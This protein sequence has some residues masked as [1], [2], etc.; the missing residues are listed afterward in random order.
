MTTPIFALVIGV[1]NYLSDHFIT[2]PAAQSDAF[3]LVRLLIQQGVPES[4]I[5]FLDSPSVTS[6]EFFTCVEKIASSITPF[7]LLFYFCGH[8]FRTEGQIP[9]SYL[10][11]SDSELNQS[12]CSRGVQLEGL[13]QSFCN[14]RTTSIYVFIDACHLRLNTVI[15]PKLIEEIQG[16]KDSN[17]TLFCLFSS[18]I[19]PSYE[20]VHHKFGYFTEALIKALRDIVHTDRSPEALYRS[21]QKT[22]RKNNLPQPE[23][24]NIGMHTLDIFPKM[25]T[26]QGAEKEIKKAMG[27]IYSCGIVIDEALFCSVID[28]EM[29]IFKELEHLDLIFY[30][31]GSW[32]PQDRLNEIVERESLKLEPGPTKSYWFQQFN[33]LP[34]HFE[35]AIHFVMSIQCF[36]YEP[37]YDESLQFAYKILYK[38]NAQS[39]EILKKSVDIYQKGIDSKSGRYLA[40]ILIELQY[41]D[42]SKTLLDKESNSINATHCHLLWRTG[43]F[44]ECIIK[45]TKIINTL[46][47]AQAKVPY[48]WHR[49]TTYY[50]VGDWNKAQSDFSFIEHNSNNSS[51]VGRSLCLSGTLTGIRGIHIKESIAKVEKGIKIVMKSGDISGTWVGWNNLGEIMWKMGD[52][53]LSQI[54]LKKA[55]DL[56]QD[57]KN[58]N[59]ILET[60]RNFVQLE[61]QKPSPSAAF[62]QVLLDQIKQLLAKPIEIFESMQI[63]NTL[64]SAYLFLDSPTIAQL[65]LKKAIP[66]TVLSKE[67]HIYTLSNLAHLCNRYK[68]KEKSNAYFLK[69]KAL[70]QAGNNL[71][72]MQQIQQ[73]H[74]KLA[75][76]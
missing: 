52:F 68:L 8:G 25:S 76:Y 33:E 72:A 57:T 49:G 73:D 60:L 67:Y 10:I 22:L 51:Y 70:A 6:A 37:V 21:I 54:Y 58:N 53:K 15:N 71:F 38:H 23:M 1:S 11:F 19:L 2:L 43:L 18:G 5:C 55:L 45:A 26:H 24:Y 35:A 66:L 69:A 48:L 39:L 41:F 56:S 63:Y 29:N 47:N 20:S 65:Y 4:N 40:E 34:D 62:I 30:E 16:K 75:L 14:M 7:Q 28:I 50:L 3:N 61:L 31:K 27:A 42:L 64:C 17:K 32:H 12:L 9:Q 59:M 44:S 74:S 36:G 13:L 46:P